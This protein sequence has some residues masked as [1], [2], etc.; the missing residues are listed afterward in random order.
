[1]L[2]KRKEK[3]NIWKIKLQILL[4]TT[5]DA[6]NTAIVRVTQASRAKNKRPCLRKRSQE[7]IITSHLTVLYFFILGSS[8]NACCAAFRGQ[9]CG[10]LLLPS[11]S[12]LVGNTIRHRSWNEWSKVM[13]MEHVRNRKCDTTERNIFMKNCTWPMALK[14]YTSKHSV[15]RDQLKTYKWCQPRH[16]TWFRHYPFCV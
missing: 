1:M 4:R 7:Y 12:S 5:T 11:V 2:T 15:T 13:K 9:V 14:L 10:L 8:G 3:K 16:A 6:R